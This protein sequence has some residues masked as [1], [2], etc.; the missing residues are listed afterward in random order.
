[1]IL[2]EVSND[3]SF[4]VL[5]FQKQHTL[6]CRAHDIRSQNTC[7]DRICQCYSQPVLRTI[8]LGM[9]C[10]TYSSHPGQSQWANQC[11]FRAKHISENQISAAHPWGPSVHAPRLGP[12][13]L[14]SRPRHTH[15]YKHTNTQAAH[16]S[17][18]T[19]HARMTRTHASFRPLLLLLL[20]LL[21]A[22]RVVGR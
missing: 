10:C 1:M 13:P 4:P 16:H 7:V 5:L 22:V 14:T 2:K 19:R 20:L 18:Q 6:F 15:T 3:D 9:S 21:R 12:R 11:T 8:A 17:L